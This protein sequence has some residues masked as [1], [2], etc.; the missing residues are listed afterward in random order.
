MRNPVLFIAGLVIAV[1]GAVFSLQ[2]FG[3]LKGSSMSNTTTW[4]TTGPII[5]IVGLVIAGLGVGKRSR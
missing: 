4:S 1:M 2:G 3:V 5:V